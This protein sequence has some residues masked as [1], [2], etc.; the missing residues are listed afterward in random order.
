MQGEGQVRVQG[1]TAYPVSAASA[2]VRVANYVPFLHGHGVDLRFTPTLSADDYSLLV[3]SAGAGRKA[4]VLARSVQRAVALRDSSELFLVH[5]LLL[6]TPLPWIDPP[7][8]LD[9]YDFDDALTVG[10]A[11]DT[12]RRFQWTKQEGRRALACMSRARLVIAANSNLAAQARSHAKRVEVVPSCVDPGSQPVS[13]QAEREFL[14][15]GW[16]GSHTTVAYLQPLLPVIQRLIDHGTRAKLIVVGGDTGLRADWIEHRPWSLETAP[17]DLA[18]FDVGVMPLPDTEWTRGKSGYK[19]L[20]YFAAGVPG[21]ASP[22]GVN[23]ELVAE[24]RGLTATTDDQWES[25]LRE[26]RDAS[27][28][29]DRGALARRFV[30]ENYS[31]QRW[32]PELARLFGELRG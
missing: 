18:D 32:A 24:G 16:I 14:H 15:I 17:G 22:V 13:A 27:A 1:A 20:Q 8:H 10:S 21:I 29:R 3:S 26:L 6:M 19:L 4:A 12:N 25:A 11:A 31:Y 9:V 30:E 23:A 5:R 2:R 28:R 7:R